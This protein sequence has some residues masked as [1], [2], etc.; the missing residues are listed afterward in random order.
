MIK[1]LKTILELTNKKSYSSVPRVTTEQSCRLEMRDFTVARMSVST[2]S[3]QNIHGFKM[4]KNGRGNA[5]MHQTLN[6]HR[7][8]SLTLRHHEPLTSIAKAYINAT[9][10]A[11]H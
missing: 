11:S 6:G 1:D 4:L 10:T 9:K 3:S 5:P 2:L 8:M 7:V